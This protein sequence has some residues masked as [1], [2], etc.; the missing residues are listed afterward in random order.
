VQE[1][2]ME[3]LKKSDSS[4]LGH[5]KVILLAQYE[6]KLVIASFLGTVAS[7]V[8]AGLL[9]CLLVLPLAARDPQLAFGLSGP[10]AF[11]FVW[12]C[13]MVY[14]WR[15]VIFVTSLIAFLAV[16]GVAVEAAYMTFQGAGSNDLIAAIGASIVSMIPLLF[17]WRILSDGCRLAATPAG[18]R[19]LFTAADRHNRGFTQ[20]FA[21][22]LG[23]HPICRWLPQ[24]WRRL[25]ARGL[26]LLAATV[27]GL[28]ILL[29]IFWLTLFSLREGPWIALTLASTGSGV[30]AIVTGLFRYLARRFARVSV[31]NLTHVDPRAPI[32]F[33]RSFKDDQVGLD[34]PKRGF[35]RAFL[36]VGDP[37]PTLDHVLLEE[38]TQLGPVVAIGVPGASAPFGAARTY[39]DDSEWQNVVAKLSRDARA[40]V[41]AL[42]DT[43]GVNWELS[44]IVDS[45]HLPKTLHLLP[46]R[47][48]ARTE[49]AAQIIRRALLDNKCVL[50]EPLSEPCIGWYRVTNGEMVL[51]VSRSPNQASYVGA[52]RLFRENQARGYIPEEDKPRPIRVA[53]PDRGCSPILRRR[54][55]HA[56]WAQC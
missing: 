16:A 21:A 37:S 18:Q 33:L 45:G 12:S 54:D 48:A 14:M 44:H 55:Y 30:L 31:E 19:E 50:T 32:L 29:V 11:F 7:G 8:F 40:I 49:G 4:Q 2:T 28:T 9:V 36:D 39:A 13:A 17:A 46:A 27:G 25:I 34:R 42:D 43:E 51:L 6:K 35:I 38:F 41:I 53:P 5:A 22:M 3:A 20:M 56:T 23:I 52:L 1:L 47:F 24:V 26:F 15:P 10:L